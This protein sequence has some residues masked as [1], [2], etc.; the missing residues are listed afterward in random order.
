[1]TL[2]DFTIKAMKHQV[3]TFIAYYLIEIYILDSSLYKKCKCRI[4]KK[5]IVVQ[6]SL[7][8]VMPKSANIHIAIQL[9]SQF[10]SH[11]FFGANLHSA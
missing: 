5:Q 2:K 1:M 3:M 9:H 6:I 4:E 7:D 10:Q 8:L 11:L